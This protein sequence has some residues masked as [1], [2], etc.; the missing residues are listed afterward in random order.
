MLL[1]QDARSK[2]VD[3]VP[4]ENR[5]ARLGYDRPGI[6]FG[7]NEVNRAAVFG[8][9]FR[10]RPLV[11]VEAAQVRQERGMNV[12]EASSPSL[13]EWGAQQRMNPARHTISARAAVSRVSS[14]ASN[15]GLPV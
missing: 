3:V 14:A 2:G 12:E 7:G 15:A 6:E 11:G 13:D 1:F 10:E 9:P 4:P 5:H 8:E